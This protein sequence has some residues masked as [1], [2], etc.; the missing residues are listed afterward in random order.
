M[1]SVVHSL[2][3]LVKSLVEVVWS[4]FTTAVHLVQ[5][6]L[7]FAAKFLTSILNV[8]VEFFQGLVDLAG[9]I[10]SFILGNIVILIVIG[11][12][13]FAFLQYQR[14]QGNTV[15]VGNKKLN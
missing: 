5:N 2:T 9:G 12:A 7:G 6:T 11:G 15:K 4:F 10:A 3:D 13:F 14:N 8:I 1:S